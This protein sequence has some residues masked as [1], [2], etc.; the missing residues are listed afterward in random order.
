MSIVLKVLGRNFLTRG[1]GGSDAAPPAASQCEEINLN[2][3]SQVEYDKLN[4]PVTGTFAGVSGWKWNKS[5][6]QRKNNQRQRIEEFVGGHTS[7]LEE[8]SI[9]KDW[10]G[11]ALHGIKFKEL[12]EKQGLTKRTIWVPKVETGIYSILNFS[13]RLYS[14]GSSCKVLNTL[15]TET[16][17]SV[18]YKTF[19]LP[20][21]ALENSINVYLF[22]RDTRFNNIPYKTFK[23]ASTLTD[24]FEFKVEA[25]KLFF[26]EAFTKTIG[27]DSN[28]ID[29][30]QCFD[31][32]LGIGNNRRRIFYTEFFPAINPIVK[33]IQGSTVHTWTRVDDFKNSSSGDRHYIF[34]SEVGKVILSKYDK[35]PYYMKS[36]DASRKFL[37][38]FYEVKGVP[39]EGK[40]VIG[41]N[42]VSYK[43]VGKYGFYLENDF[44]NF[45]EGEMVSAI[46][47]GKKLG[48]GEQIFISYEHVPRVDFEVAEDYFYNKDLNIKPYTKIESNGI[49]EIG[50]DEK[51]LSKIHLSCDKE[52]IV[53]NTYQ[54]LL[55]QQDSTLLTAKALNSNDK[56]VEEQDISFYSEEGAFEGDGIGS[57]TE[58][59]NS[60]GEAHTVYSY[61]YS[62]NNLCSVSKEYRVADSSYLEIGSTP[63]GTTVNDISVF[64]ILKT[65]SYYG[66]L[67]IKVNASAITAHDDTFYKVTIED[68]VLDVEDY[69]SNQMDLATNDPDRIVREELLEDGTSKKNAYNFAI[70][71][72]EFSNSTVSEK[73]AIKQI[74]GNS[75]YIYKSGNIERALNSQTINAI[76][77]FKKDELVFEKPFLTKNTRGVNRI[78]YKYSVTNE[79]YERL[80]P[81]RIEGTKLWFDNIILP[82]SSM[83][84]D[85]IITA[86]YKI[87]MPR[88]VS[89]YA[90][91]IDPA[92][93]IR[94]RSNTITIKVDFPNYL[95][96]DLGFKFKE[97]DDEESGGLG[98]AN[99]ISINP[100]FANNQI[101]F[102]V[103]N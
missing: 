88:K 57:I 21:E 68:T 72:L 87:V 92:T 26:L 58:V 4:Y 37:E 63:S 81:S 38:T 59:T 43:E 42:E 74:V 103:E 83:V 14:N 9:I 45:V 66:S 30:I 65:D 98:G 20:S 44:N 11:G 93:G 78:L 84:D 1:L 41:G 95:K 24:K 90:E 48:S 22:K 73:A 54:T 97:G 94:I 67:G 33:T 17:D 18:S 5:I 34:D 28:V 3:S 80:V 100:D 86:G 25:N 61:P 55:I 23:Y 31:E 35:H 102:F 7:N 49:L 39:R 16:I 32:L 51:H 13:K 2:I 70:C 6:P 40:V 52:E 12:W 50:V 8:G 69:Q 101:N 10:F 29:I 64:Q 53:E 47:P 75:V 99:F 19:Q 27:T 89:L 60:A 15:A 96:S 56:P 71:L 62:D 46:G 36:Y 82:E 79:R 76:R 77:L 85:S 91:G